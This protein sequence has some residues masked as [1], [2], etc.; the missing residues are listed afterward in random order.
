[1]E[2]RSWPSRLVKAIKK[3]SLT[4]TN[5]LGKNFSKTV[6]RVLSPTGAVIYDYRNT[7]NL[8]CFCNVEAK[9][10]TFYVVSIM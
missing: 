9:T 6:I 10:T 4:F 3:I 8:I 5:Q 1:M 7:F 2:F